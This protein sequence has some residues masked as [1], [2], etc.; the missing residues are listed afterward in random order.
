MFLLNLLLLIFFP[1]PA[2]AA[3]EF[4]ITQ[5]IQYQIDTSGNA[6]VSQEIELTNNF[7]KFIPKNIKLVFLLPIF[8][9]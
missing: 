7:P 4:Q 5:N 3:D 6:N 2:F 9:I 8:K 1:H